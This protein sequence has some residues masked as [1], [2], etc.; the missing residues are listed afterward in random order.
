MPLFKTIYL[1]LLQTSTG[2]CSSSSENIKTKSWNDDGTNHR[3][4][5]AQKNKKGTA[6]FGVRLTLDQSK[7]M[8]CLIECSVVLE[9]LDFKTVTQG[10]C[11]DAIDGFPFPSLMRS[12]THYNQYSTK[13]YPYVNF[14]LSDSRI[15]DERPRN[16]LWYHHQN[17]KFQYWRNV[18]QESVRWS[19]S[20]IAPVNSPNLAKVQL[21][22]LVNIKT[23]VWNSC[24][25][26]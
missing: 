19:I 13:S 17:N 10:V 2:S 6:F 24:L 14:S 3:E 18:V 12:I 1:C 8:H 16:E 22:D 15:E 20:H 21:S 11:T 26:F 23:L 7:R 4:G 9:R 25:L 5:A